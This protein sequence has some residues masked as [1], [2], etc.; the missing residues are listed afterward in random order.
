VVDEAQDADLLSRLQTPG[1]P[2]R[3]ER[4]IVISVEAFDWN[5][6]LHITPRFTENEMRDVMTPLLKEVVV[7]RAGGRALEATGCAAACADVPAT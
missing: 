4:A 1:Y 2:A 3:A 5:S 7:L 6:P